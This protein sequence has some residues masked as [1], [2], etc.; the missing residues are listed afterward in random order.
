[1]PD[2]PHR[3][4]E[5]DRAEVNAKNTGWR[6]FVGVDAAIYRNLGFVADFQSIAKAP[7]IEGQKNLWSAGLRYLVMPQ[8]QC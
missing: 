5:L 2:F 8:L 3:R 1:M 4:R 7:D 6:G